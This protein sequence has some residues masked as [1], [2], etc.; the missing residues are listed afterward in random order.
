MLHPI[1]NIRKQVGH[2]SQTLLEVLEWNEGGHLPS[3][4]SYPL[5]KF[6]Q[7]G[8]QIS[9]MANARPPFFAA[10]SWSFLAISHTYHWQKRKEHLHQQQ[11]QT[12]G[13]CPS[14]CDAITPCAVVASYWAE[15]TTAPQNLYPLLHAAQPLDNI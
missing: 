3:C 6:L 7:Q 5:H 15:V 2:E 12:Y 10:E 11:Q 4:L 1:S 9:S 13:C 8:E 14:P